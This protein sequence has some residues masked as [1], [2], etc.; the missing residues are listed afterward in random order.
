MYEALRAAGYAARTR[1]QTR[2]KKPVYEVFLGQLASK[3]DAEAL[4]VSIR[5]KMGVTEQ[6]LYRWKR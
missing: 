6:S 5:G 4:A 2:E 3:A 1:L